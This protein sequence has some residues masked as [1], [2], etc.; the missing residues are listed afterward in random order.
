V[1][2]KVSLLGSTGAI[3]RQTLE[4]A[5]AL[6]LEGC[7]LS[8]KS[9]IVLLERQIRKYGPAV[10]AVYDEGAARD[11]AVRVRDTRV[12]VVSGM[13]G[14]VEAA[15]VG[16]AGTVVTA[17]VGTV[18][19]LPTLAA[20][21][22]G[23]R[24][25]LAN[26]ETLV[27]AGELVMRAAKERG[28][29]ILPVDSEH[30]AIFQCLSGS[31]KTYEKI[32]LTASGG[33]FRGMTPDELQ[34]VTLEDALSHPSWRMGRKITVDS[35]TLMNKGLE[36]IEA[37]HLYGARPDQIEIV[38]HP[39][40]IVHSMVRFA[41][42]SVLAQLSVPD[43]RLPI[44][45]ALTYPERRASLTP[46]LDLTRLGAL[47]FEKPDYETF[48]CLALALD[49]ARIR[50]TACAVMNAA[51]EA[52]VSL[53]LEGRIPFS[54]IYECVAAALDTIQNNE[55]PTVAEILAADAEARRCVFEYNG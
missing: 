27:C 53:F 54:Q 20:I 33:P 18:G 8:A 31:G 4:V 28:A 52:A 24:I 32:L 9:D 45:Y 51:N 29:Q 14:L 41:D 40:S 46:P 16:D 44:Q 43:M 37:M 26:K 55:N 25:A 36:F 5:D 17:V 49:T 2:Q 13:G 11:L 47:T 21:K 39:Q 48:R 22:E 30:S 19:L 6:G 1:N 23:K 12:K 15:T 34:K 3:G 50:G 10:A 35:A 38:V 42:N 7:A